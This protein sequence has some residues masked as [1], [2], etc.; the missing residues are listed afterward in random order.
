MYAYTSHDEQI[1]IQSEDK[2]SANL[3]NGL[4]YTAQNLK[5]QIY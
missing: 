3:W 4:E 2:G 1:N 5:E